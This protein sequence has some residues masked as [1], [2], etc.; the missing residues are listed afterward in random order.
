MDTKK[1]FSDALTLIESDSRVDEGPQEEGFRADV[2]RRLKAATATIDAES[3][4][5]LTE[6]GLSIL[7]RSKDEGIDE[8]AIERHGFL[9][10]R[11]MFDGDSFE[12]ALLASENMQTA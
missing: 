7:R 11:I 12:G 2:E 10:N 9:Y 6:H 8:T 3:L 4:R 5:K 1:L